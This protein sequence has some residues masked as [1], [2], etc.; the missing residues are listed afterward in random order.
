M[1]APSAAMNRRSCRPHPR[2]QAVPD[3]DERPV[4]A[5]D[6]AILAT[7]PEPPVVESSPA[8]SAAIEEAPLEVHAVSAPAQPES[9]NSQPFESASAAE[10]STPP[11]PNETERRRA[12][13][14]ALKARWIAAHDLDTLLERPA[15]SN[16]AD[17]ARSVEAAETASHDAGTTSAHDTGT[18]EDAGPL[19]RAPDGTEGDLVRSSTEEPA[20]ESEPDIAFEATTSVDESVTPTAEPEATAV[21]TSPIAALNQAA[22]RKE[23]TFEAPK[24]PQAASVADRAGQEALDIAALDEIA[25]R[26]EPTFDAP[27]ARAEPE[28]FDATS[29]AAPEAS[30]EAP[31][32]MIAALRAEPARP[33][34]LTSRLRLAM[35]AMIS[36]RSASP[37]WTRRP[38]ARS[39]PSTRLFSY[40]LRR[41]H[42]MAS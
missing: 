41:R 23:P 25:G 35:R 5:A 28:R 27:V 32:E 14:R 19:V 22:G 12:E 37:R 2:E 9:S 31:D 26:R 18:G 16:G 36:A 29:D 11:E 38:G 42:R 1:N 40:S 39:R 24:A 7:T 6:T 15:A 4:Q 13:A 8:A 21:Q 3:Q 17:V 30:V 20:A 10:A 33:K 34:R